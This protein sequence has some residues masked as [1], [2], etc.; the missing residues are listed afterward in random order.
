MF[1]FWLIFWSASPVQ[2]LQLTGKKKKPAQSVLQIFQF[3]AGR[4][5][6]GYIFS[7]A[8]VLQ[9][10]WLT[11]GYYSQRCRVSSPGPPSTVHP[12]LFTEHLHLSIADKPPHFAP[13]W[14]VHEV[15]WVGANRAP[16]PPSLLA[17]Q[18]WGPCTWAPQFSFCKK[19]LWALLLHWGTPQLATQSNPLSDPEFYLVTPSCSPPPL[20]APRC[21]PGSP[22]FSGNVPSSDHRPSLGTLLAVC[23]LLLPPHP[24]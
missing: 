15:S 6:L 7:F 17:G 10:W 21:Q 5:E 13:F 18:V 24:T 2:V 14:S 16:M 8:V 23:R 4:G 22:K 20:P 3:P 9:G 1:T 11:L 12:V 19:S